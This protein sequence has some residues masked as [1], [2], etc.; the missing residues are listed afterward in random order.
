MSNSKPHNDLQSYTGKE[1]KNFTVIKFNH[2]EL[3]T[4]VVK[5]KIMPYRKYLFDCKC[6]FCNRVFTLTKTDIDHI[7]NII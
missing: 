6:K 5:D 3:L 1:F 7:V 2:S 4:R